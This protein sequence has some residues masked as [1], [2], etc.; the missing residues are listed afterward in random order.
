MVSKEFVLKAQVRQK[1]GTK[2]AAKLRADG[3]IPVVIYGHNQPSQS[4]AV[5]L[6]D[7]TEALHAERRVFDVEIDGNVEKLLLKEVQYDYL[8][9]NFIHADLVRVNLTEKV[10]VSV[11]LA[12]KGTAKGA[13]DGGLLEEHLSGI[14]VECLVTN[15]PETLDISVRDLGIG[16]S[17]HAKDIA[18]P[19]GVVLMDDPD[20]LII[21]CQP[22]AVE[23]AT[24]TAEDGDEQQSPEV[25]TERKSDDEEVQK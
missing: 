14:E 11:G 24:E 4:I 17:I 9:K 20:A 16:D 6:R 3:K 23:A 18:L 2:D 25:I 15:I 21:A 1:T 19:D 22:P 10:K 12:F 13:V 8:G 5:D 7:I